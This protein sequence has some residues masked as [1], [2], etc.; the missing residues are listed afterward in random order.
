MTFLITLISLIII[1]IDTEFWQ[2]DWTP[3]ITGKI[4]FKVDAVLS[5]RNPRLDTGL[6]EPLAYIISN[7]SMYKFNYWSFPVSY[8]ALD[9]RYFLFDC[10]Q[11]NY[12]PNDAIFLGPS[13]KQAFIA[14]DIY[15]KENV[16]VNVPAYH[17]AKLIDD[18]NKTN[19]AEDTIKVQNMKIEITPSNSSPQSNLVKISV[20]SINLLILILAAF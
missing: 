12:Q 3:N 2:S 4:P 8:E 10:V 7:S 16:A 11:A 19:I 20:F 17:A 14:D 15:S 18:K 9:I 5:W 1:F 13:Y 6:N